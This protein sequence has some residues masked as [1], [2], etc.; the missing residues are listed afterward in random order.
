MAVGDNK[1]FDWSDIGSKMWLKQQFDQCHREA[2]VI[3]N[4]LT[5]LEQQYWLLFR[6]MKVIE[7]KLDH[8]PWIEAGSLG[9]TFDAPVRK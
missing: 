7:G 1:P 8:A 6:E 3:L 4:N 5:D 2:A 9:I